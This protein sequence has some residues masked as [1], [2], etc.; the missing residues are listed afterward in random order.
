M[1]FALACFSVVAFSVGCPPPPPQIIVEGE[2]EGPAGEGEGEGEGGEGE[3][4][5]EGPLDGLDVGEACN[6]D[7][8][9]GL[10]CATSCR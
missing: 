4:E 6:V 5:G 9:G 3:G 8:S 1:R 10:R 2:G 7:G